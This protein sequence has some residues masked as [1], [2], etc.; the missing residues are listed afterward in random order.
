[1]SKA[2]A[3]RFAVSESDEVSALFVRPRAARWLLALAHGAGAGMRHP[4]LE[5]MSDKLASAGVATFRYQFPYME[6]QRGI[7]DSPAV[8][9]ATV[10]AAVRKAAET[11]PDLPLLAGGKSLGGR[12]SSTAAA[13]QPL[14]GVRGLVFLGFPLHPPRRPST[15][16]AD[17]LASVRI[18]MLFVQ[19]TRDAL[20]ELEL[21]RPICEQ[22]GPRATLHVVETADHS[23][24][25]LKRSGKSQEE[26]MRD[27]AQ[28]IRSWADELEK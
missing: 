23:F 13:Q 14:E 7:P 8:L 1:M 22:L 24:Q 26:I 20:A 28:A 21:L 5:T 10:T 6:K 11:A 12:M 16:R 25:V 27:T 9:T 4:F 2:K 17:H 3:L 15:K 19:G 18:P